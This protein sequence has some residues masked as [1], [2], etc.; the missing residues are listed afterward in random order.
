MG[1]FAF[2]RGEQQPWKWNFAARDFRPYAPPMSRRDGGIDLADR[3][4]PPQAAEISCYFHVDLRGLLGGGH[5]QAKPVSL[6]KN[7]W[8]QAILQ[9]SHPKLVFCSVPPWS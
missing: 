5:S 8:L 7:P 9:G 6:R 1:P 2:G 4:L 3:R